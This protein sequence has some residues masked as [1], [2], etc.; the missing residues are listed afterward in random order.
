[1][2]RSELIGKVYRA[3]N[4]Y[5]RHVGVLLAAA[6]DAPGCDAGLRN[7]GCIEWREPIHLAERIKAH[8]LR[9]GGTLKEA[10]LKILPD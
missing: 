5:L 9:N 7:A 2:D 6:L 1:M 3:R 8:K 4:A 10:A